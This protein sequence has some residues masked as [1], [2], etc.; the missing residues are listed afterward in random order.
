MFSEQN[1]L[2]NHCARITVY[3]HLKTLQQL[4]TVEREGSDK[5]GHWKINH[6]Q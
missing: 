4:G 5:T 1:T 6:H 2:N 3:R